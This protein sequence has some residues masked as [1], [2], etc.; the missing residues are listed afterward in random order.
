MIVRSIALGELVGVQHG[1]L[2]RREITLGLLHGGILGILVGAVGLLWT[3]NNGV[4]F[5]LGIAMVGNMVVAGA[6]GAGVP[7][8]LR[9]MGVDPAVASAVIVTTFTDVL[10]FLLY[11]GAASLALSLIV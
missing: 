5:V 4:A 2:L 9:R 8:F 11:L 3:G 7:L 1:S 10:G 6:T